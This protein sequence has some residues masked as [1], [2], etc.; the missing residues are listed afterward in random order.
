MIT[1]EEQEELRR[2][3]EMMSLAMGSGD[4]E[5]AAYVKSQTARIKELQQRLR[6]ER[7]EQERLE[8]IEEARSR[9]PHEPY[10]IVWFQP[11]CSVCDQRGEV[12][13]WSPANQ[14]EGG[15]EECGAKPVKYVP[16]AD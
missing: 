2:F 13:E 12:R 7:E 14:W 9:V 15:C 16:A 6:E 8:A 5:A 11:W 3:H 4:L 10:P 1:P